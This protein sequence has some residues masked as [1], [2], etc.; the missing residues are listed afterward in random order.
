[1]PADRR[2][3]QQ[4]ESVQ[5]SDPPADRPSAPVRVGEQQGQHRVIGRHCD[6]ALHRDQV[7]GPRA[8]RA[9]CEQVRQVGC[10]VPTEGG[11]WP[12]RWAK[13]RDQRCRQ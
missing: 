6:D 11:E 13:G 4:H 3:R 5:P 1:M 2:D 8:G 7:E 12:E 10:F 9:Q